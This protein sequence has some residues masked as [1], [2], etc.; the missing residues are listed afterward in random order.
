VALDRTE[1]IEIGTGVTA[2]L[3]RYHPANVAHRLATLLELYPDR[4]FLGL[5]A[6]EALNEA[7]LGNPW[8]E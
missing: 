5:G 3:N 7:P 8:P 4:V 1:D 2:I 6:G